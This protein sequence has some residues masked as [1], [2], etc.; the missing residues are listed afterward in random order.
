[1][2]AGEYMHYRRKLDKLIKPWVFLCKKK[3][4]KKR[5]FKTFH[6]QTRTNLK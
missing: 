5:L 1:M 3:P 2:E 4:I 6:E